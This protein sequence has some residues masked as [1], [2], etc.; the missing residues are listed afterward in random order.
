MQLFH[1]ACRKDNRTQPPF[2]VFHENPDR[3]VWFS[4]QGHLKKECLTLKYARM[5][6]RSLFNPFTLE[7]ARWIA[8]E[9]S[10]CFTILQ[11]K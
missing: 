6:L 9:K 8:S 2:D 5:R 10:F 3:I 1:K 4:S 7:L 11:N